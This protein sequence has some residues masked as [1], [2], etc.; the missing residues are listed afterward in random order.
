MQDRAGFGPAGGLRIRPLPGM[1]Q[2]MSSLVARRPG[3]PL[4]RIVVAAS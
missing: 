4:D 1:M 2:A 3:A